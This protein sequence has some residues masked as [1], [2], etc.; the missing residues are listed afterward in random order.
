MAIAD[1]QRALSAH[2]SGGVTGSRRSRRRSTV[3]RCV[4][5]PLAIAWAVA[6][7]EVDGVLVE[8]EAQYPI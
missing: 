8:I 5:M 4:L 2:V 6:L 3:R 7:H 1:K